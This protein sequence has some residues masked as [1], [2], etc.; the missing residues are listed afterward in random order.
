MSS[1]MKYLVN[2]L[3]SKILTLLMLFSVVLT[4]SNQVVAQERKIVGNTLVFVTD[5]DSVKRDSTATEKY[6]IEKYFNPS[7][8]EEERALHKQ[9][10][11]Q[12]SDRIDSNIND[13]SAY[14]NRGAYYSYLG[15]YVQAINDYDKAIEIYPNIPEVYYNR[16]LAKA[17]FV[18][19]L[20]A[21]LDLKKANELGLPQAQALINQNCRRHIQTMASEPGTSGQ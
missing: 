19:T 9:N 20:D 4:L 16:A 15:L 13:V 7:M 2:K 6:D 18:Y 17:R 1:K 3:S 8:S 5:A 21:C 10:I 14:V 12:F 11:Q